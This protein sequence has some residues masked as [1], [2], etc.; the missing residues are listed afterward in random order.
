LE[1]W[2][3]CFGKSCDEKNLFTSH[4]FNI[5]QVTGERKKRKKPLKRELSEMSGLRQ[6][7]GGVRVFLN[8]NKVPP[9]RTATTKTRKGSKRSKK[10]DSGK[11]DGFVHRS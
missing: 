10:G 6:E 5:V 11:W 8:S 2:L 9:E 7:R 4:L 3:G 1:K